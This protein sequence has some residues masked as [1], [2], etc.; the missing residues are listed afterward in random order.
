M[1]ARRAHGADV[2]HRAHLQHLR[3]AHGVQRRPRRLELHHASAARRAHHASTA[4]ASRRARFASSPI[5]STG[6]CAPRAFADFDSPVNIGNSREITMI[7][8]AEVVMKVAGKKSNCVTFRFRP[9]IPSG[10]VPTSRRQRSCS[11]STRRSRS[12]T[13]STRPTRTSP[14]ACAFVSDAVCGMPTG[15][16]TSRRLVFMGPPGAG[17][18]TQAKLVC[19]KLGIPQ[20]STGD[21]LRGRKADGT[22]PAELVKIMAAG[23]LV[24]DEVVV[25][26]IGERLGEPDCENG[27]LLD[28]FPRTVAQAEGPRH[29]ARGARPKARPRARPRSA[30]RSS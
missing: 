24:P 1:D 4:T 22:L 19:E 17:K 7:E 30:R 18:G 2:A 27:F 8:L 9:T 29:D 3:S 21:M 16:M 5:S 20:V 26:L 6:S 13:A 28:G 14:S 11:A 25:D 12:S 15:A 23:G 10:D